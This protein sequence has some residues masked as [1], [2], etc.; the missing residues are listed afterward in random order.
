MVLMALDHTRGMVSGSQIDPTNLAETNAALFL[1]R[2][3]THFCAPIFVF[4]AG[5]AA[6]LST[7]RGKTKPEL[8]RF[9][10]TRGLWLIFLEFTFVRLGWSF[11]LKSPFVV[12]QVIWVLGCSMSVLAVLVYLPIRAVAIFGILTVALHNCLDGIR[13]QD[14]GAYAWVWGILHGGYS[15]EMLPGL[16]FVPSYALIPWVGVMAAGYGF[17]PM[18]LLDA[19]RRR[20]ILLWL[21]FGLMA[22][23]VTIRLTNQYGDPHP[24]SVQRSCLYTC[25]SFVN[26]TKYP[27][28][29]LFLL[30]T[31]GPGILF[32]AM[33][34]GEPEGAKSGLLTRGLI[35]FGRVP[36]FFYLLHLPLIHLL[37]VMVSL[38]H[39]RL[40]LGSF[41]Y[42]R[43][44]ADSG[45]GQELWVV[46]AI[47]ILVVCLLFPAC[48][49][50]ARLKQRRPS[51][52]LSYL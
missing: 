19:S 40:A 31:L 4:L 52:W 44:P 16:K 17:G 28:S 5:T 25:F 22:A 46:Y 13:A 41:Y 39:Y 8:S 21:G 32:L 34:R 36:L 14:F 37:A 38:P 11:S 2:W 20:Q 48:Y 35:V 15:F 45:Y 30:M 50:F 49:W 6:F 12:G 3:I 47:W 29:L 26:C 24:W 43:P 42:A 51:S 1:T 10:W 33:R 27:P 18:L 9:L 7:A 23:F